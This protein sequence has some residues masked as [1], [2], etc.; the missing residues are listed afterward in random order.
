MRAATWCVLLAATAGDEPVVLATLPEGIA[1]HGLP[2]LDPNGRQR[3]DRST[4]V[5]DDAVTR[6]AYVGHRGARTLAIAGDESLGD[7]DFLE[8]PL[9]PPAPLPVLFRAGDR[10]GKDRE[11]WWLLANAKKT[12]P[13][14]W[15]GAVA[16]SADGANVAWWEQPGAK[17]AKDGSSERGPQELCWNGKKLEKWADADSLE[18][19]LFAPDGSRVAAIVEKNGWRVALASP[20]K[21]ELLGDGKGLVRDLAWRPDGSG[22]VWCESASIGQGARMLGAMVESAGA[23]FEVVA[24]KARLGTAFASCS[25]PVVAPDGRA[26]AYKYFQVVD[27]GGVVCGRLGIGVDDAP[28]AASQFVAVDP[29]VWSPDGRGL[30]AAVA[31][32][33]ADAPLAEQNAVNFVARRYDREAV[34]GKWHVW[35]E[36]TTSEPWDDV[37]HVTWSPDGKRLAWVGARDGK[38]HA[39]VDGKA[40]APFDAIGPLH[41]AADGRSLFFGALDGRK[42]V[43]ATQAVAEV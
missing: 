34:K 42:I 31:I 32:T 17:L 40:G 39:V 30:A 15:I 36:G 6:V 16:C 5:F 18:P 1:L 20:K 4:L 23:K 3:I 10:A 37:L 8:R 24:G 13:C 19:P 29:L 28:R 22:V 41:F 25:A 21:V 12:Q 35:R 33:A 11:R 27:T 7:F 43:R 38:Q 14:D 26:I 9:V 2:Y